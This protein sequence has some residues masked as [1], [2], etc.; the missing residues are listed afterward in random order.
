[1]PLEESLQ[2]LLDE[3]L[4]FKDHEN[5]ANYIIAQ[6]YLSGNVKA[7]FKKVQNLITEHNR[8]DLI[9]NFE[10]LKAILPK[11]L[12]ASEISATIGTSWIPLKYYCDFIEE[13]LNISKENYE[14]NYNQR[15]GEWNFYAQNFVV[16]ER[17]K[18]EYSLCHSERSKAK[19][20]NLIY[21]VI[22]TA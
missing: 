3:K 13:K 8:Q 9:S 7:K 21:F 2:N 20:R 19:S 16:S 6:K 18:A 5:S 10:S 12:K 22:L 15:S 1:M 14:I 11:D 4:I 17:I